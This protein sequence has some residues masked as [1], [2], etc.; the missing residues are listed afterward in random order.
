MIRHY[1]T[2]NQDVYVIGDIHGDFD[3]LIRNIKKYEGLHTCVIIAAGDIGL[4]FTR[5][6][7]YQEIFEQINNLCLERHIQLY[8]IRGNHDDPSYFTEE[9]INFTNVKSIPDYS[10]ISVGDTHIL[11][12]GGS[13]SI[14]RKSRLEN[15]KYRMKL[16]KTFNPTFSKKELK[17]IC[18]PSYWTN[19]IPIYN[20]EALD[21]LNNMGLNIQYVITHSSPHFAFKKN[22]NGISS[23]LKKDK[24]LGSD[25]DAERQVFTQIYHKLKADNHLLNGWIYGHFHAHNDEIIDRTR[26]VTL[27]NCDMWWDCFTLK[28][29]DIDENN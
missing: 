27:C 20:E 14:D 28:R 6:S 23:F 1:E 3:S 22:K 26:F 4:G 25:L 8:L 5:I 7:H 15:D 2:F 19:E 10:V 21:E 18:Y 13:I 9:K 29:I 12:I 24:S 16:A 17:E 11:C